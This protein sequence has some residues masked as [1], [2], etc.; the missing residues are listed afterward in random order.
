MFCVVFGSGLSILLLYLF[1]NMRLWDKLGLSK[2][3]Q[4][5][6]KALSELTVRVK[7]LEHEKLT[8]KVRTQTA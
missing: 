7:A 6:Q 1:T 4:E 3:S 8:E 5:H 2:V